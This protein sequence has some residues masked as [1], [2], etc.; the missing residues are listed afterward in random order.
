MRAIDAGFSLLKANKIAIPLHRF[1]QGDLLGLDI[2]GLE[3]W[4]EANFD[5]FDPSL[6]VQDNI[7]AASGPETLAKVKEMLSRRVER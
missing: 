4:L 6:S 2:M 3:D 1:W 7:S 5:G